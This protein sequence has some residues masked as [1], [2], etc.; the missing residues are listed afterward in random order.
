LAFCESGDAF[1]VGVSPED[2][3]KVLDCKIAAAVGA[4]CF[5]KW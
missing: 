3:V 1:L 5:A 4:D 2:D